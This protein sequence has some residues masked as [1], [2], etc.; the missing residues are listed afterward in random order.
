MVQTHLDLP[1][2]SRN[3]GSFVYQAFIMNVMWHSEI[4]VF[5]LPLPID[6]KSKLLL[7]IERRQM[8]GLSDIAFM[9]RIQPI[10]LS[11]IT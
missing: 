5:V 6:I 8:K 4:T 2:L 10:K 1:E 3:P 11:G 7:E 9:H